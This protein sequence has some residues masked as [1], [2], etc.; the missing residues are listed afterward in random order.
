MTEAKNKA[1]VKKQLELEGYLVWYPP[2]SRFAPKF[3]YCDQQHSAKDIFTL[4]DCVALKDSELRFVQYTSY[5]TRLARVKKI[6]NFYE[7]W[8]VFIPAEVWGIR[9]DK[10]YEIIYI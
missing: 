4:F 8:N 7:K 9:D 2:V 1:L 6:N 3:K 10:T 5:G